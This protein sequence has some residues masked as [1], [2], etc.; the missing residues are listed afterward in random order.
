MVGFGLQVRQ[1]DAVG[2]WQVRHAWLQTSQE[3]VESVNN[4]FSWSQKHSM[5][6]S[7]ACSKS[8][9][10]LLPVSVIFFDLPVADFR[11]PS[12]LIARGLLRICPKK[13]SVVVVVR[14][15]HLSLNYRFFLSY[16]PV[17][18]NRPALSPVVVPNPYILLNCNLPSTPPVARFLNLPTDV[19]SII[20]NFNPRLSTFPS[21]SVVCECQSKNPSLS[22]QYSEFLGSEPD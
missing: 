16:Q 12:L 14:L 18:M 17:I 11:N 22:I 8:K 10:S 6:V 3:P 7:D 2:P 21:A 1:S 19:F 15:V 13:N 5:T 9:I 20:F 4:P